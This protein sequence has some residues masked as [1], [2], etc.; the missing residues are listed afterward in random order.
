MPFVT[1]NVELDIEAYRELLALGFRAVP[2]TFV[3]E[4]R[5]IAIKGFDEVSLKRALG[6]PEPSAPPSPDR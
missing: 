6:M 4:N 5:A 2:V 1:R 3:G